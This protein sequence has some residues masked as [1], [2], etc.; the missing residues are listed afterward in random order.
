MYLSLA[1]D[2]GC[3]EQCGAERKRHAYDGDDGHA[4]CGE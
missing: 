3:V 1:D 2:N 4:G